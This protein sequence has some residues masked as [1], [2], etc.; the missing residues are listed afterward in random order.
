MRK[1]KIADYDKTNGLYKKFYKRAG[2]ILSAVLLLLSTLFSACGEAK[3]NLPIESGVFSVH[4]LDVGQGDSILINFSDGKNMLI[5]AGVKDD[6]TADYIVKCIEKSDTETLDYLLL[7]H[8]DGDHIGNA[9]AIIERFSVGKIFAPKI[10]DASV[11]PEFSAAM[12]IAIDKKTPV[13][14][15]DFYMSESGDD[16]FLAF[17]SPAPSGTNGSAY[18]GFNSV[19]NP[20][21]QAINDLSPIVYLEYKGV[22]FIFTGDAGE[23]QELLVLQNFRSGLYDNIFGKGRIKLDK[24]D[25]LKV[26][27]HGSNS[28]SGEDFLGLL[29][30]DNAVISVGKNYYGLPSTAVLKRL[31]AQSPN[32]KIYRTDVGETISVAVDS[33]GLYTI[34]EGLKQ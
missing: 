16:W 9:E 4:Y 20:S 28:A 25:F 15:P 29:T 32:V 8:P 17:L 13:I 1:E 6:A 7:T 22:R 3:I 27:H 14:V 34:S 18:D 31:I 21:A 5:D 33:N 19:E 11:Y 23:S 12:K 30:P 2:F 10:N 24:V 26:S